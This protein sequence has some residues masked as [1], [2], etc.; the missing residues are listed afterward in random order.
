MD[1]FY[2]VDREKKDPQ[3]KPIFSGLKK[4]QQVAYSRD[5]YDDYKDYMRDC[6]H[7]REMVEDKIIHSK[8]LDTDYEKLVYNIIDLLNKVYKYEVNII[9]KIIIGGGVNTLKVFTFIPSLKGRV[10]L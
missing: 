8:D 3:G 5:K 9:Q 2:K 10:Q 6:I 4:L 1:D 7:Y